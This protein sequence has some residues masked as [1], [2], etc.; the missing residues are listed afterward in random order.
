MEEWARKIHQGIVKVFSWITIGFNWFIH[1]EVHANTSYKR[2]AQK[3]VYFAND[4]SKQNTRLYE[5][6]NHAAISKQQKCSRL[7]VMWLL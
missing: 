4:F 7:V 6:D 2:W 1:V 5:D 3:C